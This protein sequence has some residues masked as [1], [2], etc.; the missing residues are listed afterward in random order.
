MPASSLVHASPIYDPP[1]GLCT[2]AP[3]TRES[4]REHDE[5]Q[6]RARELVGQ[7]GRVEQ[8][9]L[10]VYM[11]SSLDYRAWEFRFGV[12][13]TRSPPMPHGA[14]TIEELRHQRGS[15]P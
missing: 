13:I 1:S 7:V 4:A 6:P 3:S 2:P 9:L 14:W 11:A 15:P 12:L 5:N 8:H 10:V